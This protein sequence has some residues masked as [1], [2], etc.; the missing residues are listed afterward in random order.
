MLPLSPGYQ[1]SRLRL[2]KLRTLITTKSED[3]VKQTGDG[4]RR[5]FLKASSMLGKLIFFNEHEKGIHFAA[6][7]QRELFVTDLRGAF[8][9]LR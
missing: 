8:K 4:S 1:R 2:H 7:E 3:T 9:S 5:H 6:W